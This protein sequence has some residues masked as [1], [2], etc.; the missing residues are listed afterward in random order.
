M[1][2]ILTYIA[3][4]LVV[5]LIALLVGPSLV[6]WTDFRAEF[7]RQASRITGHD[8]TIE[9]DIGFRILP[10]P[11]LTLGRVTIANAPGAKASALVQMEQMDGELALAPLLSG[12][13]E[14]TRIN[15]VK[16]QISLEVA[17]NGV[18]NWKDFVEGAASAEEGAFSLASTSLKGASFSDGTI[19]YE[20]R[21]N[22]RR[23]LAE[24][25][26]GTVNAQALVGPMRADVTFMSR[27][28]P[29]S[30]SVVLGNFGGSKAFPVTLEVG[31]PSSQAEFKFSGIATEFSSAARLDGKAS[32][33]IGATENG[34]E[35]PV[36]L[37][38][39]M[40]ARST[41]ITLRDMVLSSGGTS[42]HGSGQLDISGE[43]PT[44]EANL[45]GDTF[46]A[47]R[48]AG[49][50]VRDFGAAGPV[51][52]SGSPA[53]FALL[54][55]LPHPAGIDGTFDISVGELLYGDSAFADATAQLALDNGAWNIRTLSAEAPG[56]TTVSLDGV[57]KAS[58]SG[59]STPA[60]DGRFSLASRNLQGFADW[61]RN[62]ADASS[63]RGPDIPG[64]EASRENVS[65]LISFT[66]AGKVSVTPS[67]LNITG[68]RAA[69]AEDAA[70]PVVTGQLSYDAALRPRLAA[71]LKAGNFDLDPLLSMLP[72]DS[73]RLLPFF[74]THD[75]KLQLTADAL[76]A[77][78]ETAKD[79]SA[80]ARLEN[81]ELSVNALSIGDLKGA[82]LGFSGHLAGV[83]SGKSKDIR[84]TFTGNVK[85]ERFGALLS[86]AGYDVPRFQGDVDVKVT[87]SSGE[88]DDSD[89][90]VDTLTL[91]GTVN[92]A[93][94]DAVLKRHHGDSDGLDEIEII[95][96]AAHPDGRELLSQFGLH[97]AETLEGSGSASIRMDG[98]DGDYKTSFRANIGD[99]AFT[100]EGDAKNPFSDLHFG[101]KV[102]LSAGRAATVTAAFG[103]TGALS[104]W[105][106][107]QM[108]GAG[109][110][111]SANIEWDKAHL[112]LGDME[113]VAGNFRLS[114]DL[115]YTAPANGKMADLSG[116]LEANRLD[117]T[118]L[119]GLA[120]EK[121]AMGSVWSMKA[122]DWHLL[123]D[124]TADLKFKSGAIVLGPLALKGAEG[125]LTIAD[126]AMSV[127]PLVGELA[128]GRT[129]ITARFY[130]GDAGETAPEKQIE[131]TGLVE[132]ANL[133][134]LSEQAFGASPGDGQATV[135]L[136]LKAQ[137]LSWLSLVGS[138]SGEGQL[139]LE[140]VALRPL[141]VDG[142]GKA[143]EQLEDIKAFDGAVKNVLRAGQTQ[144]RDIAG[145][146]ALKDG[147]LAF[148][149]DSVV[150]QGGKATLSAFY[151]L[152]RLA[153]DAELTV[154]GDMPKGSPAYS[155][156]AAGPHGAMSVSTDTA[157]LESH[158]SSVILARQAE[159]LGVDLPADIR[160]MIRT[161]SSQPLTERGGAANDNAGG[162]AAEVPV[163]LARP[164]R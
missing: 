60:F 58:H 99:A 91:R 90:R 22:G 134:G 163:P 159:K 116:K 87:G 80:D 35:S 132:G 110:V 128:G 158:V 119:A 121:G 16:P 156:S 15:I 26:N 70:T 17:P 118:S 81:G 155:V 141:D 107:A 59:A 30:A 46:R 138:A 32:L 52:G 135:Q 64:D 47:D 5:L 12:D 103:A 7:E 61:L 150:L 102:D 66:V 31:F 154:T 153:A 74:Q 92:G 89:R 146:V 126:G 157:K 41:S 51:E 123:R 133:A 34:G 125:E 4:A 67:A 147:V 9:G 97:P 42:L 86:M 25:V 21:T 114:G 73:D 62:N 148:E 38:A 122:I 160:S 44:F 149:D 79:V 137:G 124:L 131:F 20:N 76:T 108:Q 127:S 143:L 136:H 36:S 57:L 77:L 139:T 105:M 112:A 65:P 19:T 78:G 129:S 13:I 43:R 140:D 83:T 115:L 24:N 33:L 101:G 6:D 55:R 152:S 69:Y 2:Q 144:A 49:I 53:P 1:N 145:P 100:A 45:G 94:V 3:G 27:G 37:Q 120:S 8:V 72:E 18:P 106:L 162:E 28:T 11:R 164:S 39:G 84:G 104:D 142:F 95:A 151:D 10:A 29:M 54:T 63:L 85:A 161:P 98:I 68:L 50:F 96:N 23:W 117:V 40:V 14:V 71:K 88:A 56:L 93:R 48:L 113:T 111:G 82:A 130:A 109:F 75:M